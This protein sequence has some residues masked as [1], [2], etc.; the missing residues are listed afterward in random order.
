MNGSILWHG[1]VFATLAAGIALL[2]GCGGAA[3]ARTAG[4]SDYQKDVA[5]AHCVRSHGVPDWPD[6]LPHGGFPRTAAGQNP[7]FGSAREACRH[8]LPPR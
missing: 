8:L 7:R 2:A 5:F 3:P 4:S 1:R 6:P